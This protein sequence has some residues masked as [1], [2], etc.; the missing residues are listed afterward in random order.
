MKKRNQ[1]ASQVSILSELVSSGANNWFR[2][3]GGANVGGEMMEFALDIESLSGAAHQEVVYIGW[4]IGNVSQLKIRSESILLHSGGGTDQSEQGR[5][6]QYEQS[7][8][9]LEPWALIC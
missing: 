5:H 3:E 4:S 9:R 2:K 7:E 1:I 6:S 8:L